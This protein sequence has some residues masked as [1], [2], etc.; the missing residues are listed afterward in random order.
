MKSIKEIYWLT[1]SFVYEKHAKY[2]RIRRADKK[3]NLNAQLIVSLTSYPPRFA[4]LHLTVKTLL[5][6]SIRPDKILLWVAESDFQY[7]PAEILLL[8]KHYD[9]FLIKCCRELRSFKKLIPSLNLYPESFLVIADDDA[10]YPYD[11]LEQLVS[12]YTGKNQVIA[13]RVHKVAYTQSSILPYREWTKNIVGTIDDVLMATGVGGVLYPPGCFDKTVLDEKLFMELCPTTDD[14]WFFWM[15]RINGFETVGTGKYL[16]TVC[17]IGTHD[18]GLA[19]LNVD[20]H[21]NDKSLANMVDYF[22][23]NVL[24][25]TFDLAGDYN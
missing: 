7:L 24:L 2:M 23:F 1:E 22:G 6:Q 18:S 11:W 12:N 17:W 3:H 25:A 5:N 21:G 20:N 19:Q 10:Y 13:H 15:S 16:N 9:D 14:I 4:K 8:S